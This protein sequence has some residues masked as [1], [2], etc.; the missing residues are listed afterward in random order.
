M[1]KQKQDDQLELTYSSYMRTQDVTL[2]T[3]QRPMNNVR[4]GER[5]SGISM[6]ATRHDHDDDGDR[7]WHRKMCPADINNL[8][9]QQGHKDRI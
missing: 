1:A 6:L 7:I 5:G 4:S 3:C 8:K 9:I 2:R